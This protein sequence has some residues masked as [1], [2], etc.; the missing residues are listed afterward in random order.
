PTVTTTVPVVT[1]AGAGTTIL[2]ALQLVGVAG[3]PLKVTVLV[4]AVAPK[5]L[6]AMVIETPEDPA[7]GVRLVIVGPTVKTRPLL[8]RPPTVTTTV[9]VVVATGTG[10]TVLVALQLVGDAAMPL[11]VTVLAPCVVPKVVPA[12]VTG[13]PTGPDTGVK[14]AMFGFTVNGT[15][16]LA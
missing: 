13:V 6:P 8:A 7:G 9:P 11:N 14:V 12:I 5:F 15:P 3:V 1:P 16:L 2:V 4:P 10:T